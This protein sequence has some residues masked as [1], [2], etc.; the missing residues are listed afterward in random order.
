MVGGGE[1]AFIGAVHRMAARLTGEI[2]LV[3]GA[4]SRRA[5]SNH[6]TGNKEG[7]PKSRIYASYAALFSS[8]A[9]R[10]PA[11]RP[12]FITIVTPNDSHAPIAIA[13]ME[14][15]FDVLCDKPMADTLSAAQTMVA[16]AQRT[17]RRLGI[18]HTYAGY[19]LVKQ[20][21]ALLQHGD[22]GAV[23]RVQVN[24]TQ[25]WLSRAA[26][27]NAS[28][29]ATWRTDPARSGEG[30]A[31][32]DIGT[33][34]FHLVEY[35]TGLRVE[36]LCADIRAT[37]AGRVLD[38]DGACLF[39]LEQGARGTLTASQICTG[40]AN[41]LTLSV[42]C[43]EMA[44]HWAQETP[45]RLQVKRRDRPEEIWSPGSNR[46][47][48]AAEALMATRVPAGH[49]E[50]YIEAFANIYAAFTADILSDSHS[51]AGHGYA[52]AADALA[53][54]RFVHATRISSERNASW[55]NLMQME[56]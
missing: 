29:Q 44:L 6:L 28:A 11:E 31:M 38:D 27:T 25:D 2:D 47:Y 30:G 34:A 12:D 33:H 32:G 20:A 7:L 3:A 52:S 43:D 41:A 13:A 45:N 1:G 51:E 46:P 35:V 26:D 39:K 49:P 42:Y 24:Y 5:E 36:S 50:G 40:D 56:Q 48:L 17:G 55:V 23:R 22:A 54:M 14:A 8:E 19:P 37:L 9:Q 4:F 53:C 21:R 10:T 16:T 18:T 15:G